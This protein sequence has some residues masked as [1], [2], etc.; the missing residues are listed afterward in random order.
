MGAPRRPPQF[1][2]VS[3]AQAVK[4]QSSHGMEAQ[5]GRLKALLKGI[6]EVRRLPQGTS[7]PLLR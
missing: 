4:N 1:S 6:E 3:E 2:A 7:S 5:L